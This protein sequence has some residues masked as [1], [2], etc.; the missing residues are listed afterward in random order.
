MKKYN[1]EVKFDIDK[2]IYINI[3]SA[4]LKTIIINIL[5]N[6]IEQVEL[7]RIES[8]KIYITAIHE[9]MNNDI[10]IKIEDDIKS[11]NKKII[12][13]EI[14]TSSEEKYF[15]T[16]IYL[17]KLLIEKN[18]GLFWC[19]NSEDETKYYIKLTKEIK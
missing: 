19:K 17:A 4:E 16:S 11:K 9:N 12:L 2:E 6:C 5:K 8:T 18:S 7:N 15:D 10:L 13:D 3:L 14:L 1:I